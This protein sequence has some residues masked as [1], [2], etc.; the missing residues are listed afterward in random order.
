VYKGGATCEDV[1]ALA[2]L[3]RERV[4]ESYDIDLELE[5]KVV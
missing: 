2:K 1:L 4:R 5:V 3:V